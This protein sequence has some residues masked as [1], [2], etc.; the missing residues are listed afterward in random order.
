MGWVIGTSRDTREIL[1][2]L[3]KG[4]QSVPPTTPD[5]SIP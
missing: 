3:E 1:E 4:V 5:P 2:I